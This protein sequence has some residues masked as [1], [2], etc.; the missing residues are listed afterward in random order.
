VSSGQVSTSYSTSG[1][2]ASTTYYWRI[3]AINGAGSTVGPVWSFTTAA[4]PPPPGA[5]ANPT[6]VSGATAVNTNPTLTWSATNATSYNVKFGTTNPPPTVSSGQTQA[7]YSTATLGFNTTYFWQIVATNTNGSTAGPVWSFTTQA[8]PPPPGVPGSPSPANG[9]TG[10]STTPTLTWGAANATSYDVKFGTTNPP[11]T[12]TSGQASASFSAGSALSNNTTYFWQITANNGGGSTAGP[13]W[14]FTTAAAP[15]PPTDIVIY[16][17]DLTAANLHGGSW[18]LA[19]DATSPNSTKVSTSDTGIANTAG[20]V[21]SPAQYVDITFNAN[22][23]VAY[24]LWI[25]VRAQANSKLNDSFFVQFSDAL[26][27]GSPIYPLNSTQGLAVNLATD[28]TASSLSN[29]GWVNG[30]YWL[31]QPATFTF[32]SSGSH[33]MRFQIREDGFEFDQVVLSRSTF[34][35]AAASCPTSCAGAPGPVNND[36]T[37]VPKP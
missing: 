18:S 20:P 33:T 22:A 5:P 10:V 29:W 32:A 1:L 34:F 19:S 3:T 36:S 37:I 17:S 25:R 4:A 9:A 27:S 24:T 30:A 16:A 28:S 15:P 35:N 21:A 6:P 2:T 31:N 26:A 14:S 7:S 12:A 23:G 11:P 8:A 13:V